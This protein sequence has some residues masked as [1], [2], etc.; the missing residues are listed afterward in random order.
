MTPADSEAT[1]RLEVIAF[2]QAGIHGAVSI[3]PLPKL[4]RGSRKPAGV[5]AS[6]RS[7]SSGALLSAGIALLPAAPPRSPGL[8]VRDPAEA[9]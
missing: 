1:H 3:S 2:V 4:L 5:R 6:P 9:F 8:D 7:G